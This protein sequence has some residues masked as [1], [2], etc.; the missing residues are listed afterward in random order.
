M[1][2]P[3]TSTAEPPAKAMRMTP[4]LA[5]SSPQRRDWLMVKVIDSLAAITLS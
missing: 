1:Y 4:T 2:T 5:A 3:S